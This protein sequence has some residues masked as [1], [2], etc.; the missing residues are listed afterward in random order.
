MIRYK[1]AIKHGFAAAALVIGLSSCNDFLDRAPLSEVTPEVFLKTEADLAAYTINAY[2]FPTHGGFNVGTFGIDNGTDNQATS[3]ASNIWIPGERRVPQSGGGWSFGGI[4][5]INYFLQN[6]VPAWEAGQISGNSINIDHY[7]GEGYFLR[8]YEYFNKLQTFGDF[9]IIRGT[10]PDDLDKLTEASKR[11][12]RNE[13]ARFIISDL[14]SA[15][16][17]LGDNPLGGKV[18]I[19]K[20]AALLF[21]SRVALYEGTWLKYHKGT[22]HV[23]GG[24]GWPGEGKVDGFSINIDS[25]IEYFLAEAMDAAE[26]VADQIPL[27]TNTKDNGYDSSDNPYFTMFGSEDLTGYQEVLL[28]RDYDPSLNINHNTGHYINRNGGNTGYTR[29]FVDN[30]LM[31]NGLPI[32]APASGYA[33]DDFIADVKKDRDNRL[34]IFMKA[35]GELRVDDRTNTD[36]SA[37]LEETPDIIGL[38]ETKYVTGY[39]LKKGMSYAFEQGEGNRGSTGSIVFRA[40][41]AYLNYLEASYLKEGVVTGKAETYWKAIRDRAGVNND[42]MITVAATDMNIE[43]QNDFAAYSAGVLLSDKVL[44]N[45][46]RERRVELMAEGM[47]MFDLKRWRALDQLKTDPH[48]IEG[49]KLWGPMKEWYKDEE[50]GKTLLIQPNEEGTPNVSSEAEGEYLRPYRIVLGATNLVKDGYRW[51]YAHYLEPIAIQHFIITTPDGSGSPENSVIYQ[52][53]GWPL[54]ANSAAT[55]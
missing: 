15:I 8:A 42:F 31:A 29:E 47:R 12:P 43:A 16:M 22:A 40:A 30:V 3:N 35:P 53:P 54:Q 50:T 55:E 51:A 52:N 26:Q 39:A 44:Y 32:Y 2:G 46:R 1:K 25:E 24:P 13:V 9:P 7:I 41:E 11:R 34:Q 19:T 5:N 38:L 33:G 45:I 49:F 23:P 4:R 18:R 17:L 36:G 48:I 20:N 27:E 14:D 28:W 37:I 21:K 6:A 10:L